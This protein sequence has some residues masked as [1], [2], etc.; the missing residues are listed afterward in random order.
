[1]NNYVYIVSSLPELVKELKPGMSLSRDA[2]LEEITSQC[3]KKDREV[4]SFLLEGFEPDKLDRSF[5][6]KA[7][8]H[9]DRFIREYFRYDLDTRNAKARVLNKALGRP[10]DTDTIVLEGDE[11]HVAENQAETDAVLAQKDILSREKDLDLL[12]W[13]KAEEC[14]IFE[15]F[16]LEAILAFI[17]KLCITSRWAVMDEETGKEMFRKLSSEVRATFSGVE[18]ES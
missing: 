13:K 1:M 16:S 12:M 18:F 3:S 10:E 7:L 14:T 15:Y 6:E 5:Y 9:S 2:I 11:D 4:I 8:S 17:V